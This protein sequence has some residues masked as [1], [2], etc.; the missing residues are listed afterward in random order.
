MAINSVPMSFTDVP[1]SFGL[2]FFIK[3][4]FSGF[5]ALVLYSCAVM[6][7]IACSPWASLT[8]AKVI[9]GSFLA[10]AIGMVIT[11][12][13]LFIYQFFEGIRFWPDTMWWW[14]YERI[15]RHFK[16][17]DKELEK[18]YTIKEKI[19]AK[20]GMNKK[21]KEE[22]RKINKKLQ[23]LLVEVR[24][25]PY[26]PDEGFYSKR[27]P[28]QATIFGNV[29]AEYESYSEKQY[30]MHMTVF[31][32]HLWL[33]LPKELKE[34]LD[35]RGANA[36]LPIYLSFIFLCYTFIGGVGFYF[37]QNTWVNI[38]TYDIP[39]GAII[40][41]FLS[42]GLCFCFYQISIQAH[43]SYGRYIK[44][45]FDLYRVDLAKKL[46]TNIIV[47]NLIPSN[48]EI[49]NWLKYRYYLLDYYK[50]TDKK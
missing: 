23:K 28:E 19:A 24:K 3:T 8:I 32:S 1:M 27:Y 39:I 44:A 43:V 12:F 50:K 11:S 15:Q 4:F 26:N 10:T 25:F 18:L 30:G 45:V 47:T 33:I 14:K 13:D 46:R 16:N 41:F 21:D 7:N 29:L 34:D 35:L 48:T 31:W 37:Q 22:L 2:P 9:L 20:N 40:C 38:L 36:D 5:V 42:I 6:P 49:E 17:I